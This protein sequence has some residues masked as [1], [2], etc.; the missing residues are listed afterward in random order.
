[1]RSILENRIQNA[2]EDNQTSASEYAGDQLQYGIEDISTEAGHIVVDASQSTMRKIRK[3]LRSRQVKKHT[4]RQPSFKPPT[5]KQPAVRQVVWTV[6]TPERTIKGTQK[7]IKTTAQTS[8]VTIKTAQLTA[9]TAQQTAQAAAKARQAALATAKAVTTA[10][11]VTAKAVATA[12]K[13]IIAAAKELVAAIAAG[14][15]VSVVIIIALMLVALIVGSCFGIFFS[16][17]DTGSST[18]M[19]SVVN[20]INSDYYARLETIRE[21]NTHDKLEMSEARAVWPEVLAIYAVKVNYDL[22]SPQEVAS[23]DSSKQRQLQEIFWAMNQIRYHLETAEETVIT[24]EA[25][26]DGNIVTT[27]SIQTVTTLYIHVTHKTAAAMAQEHDFSDEQQQMLNE[28]LKDENASLWSAVLYGIHVTNEQIVTVARSQLGNIGGESYWRWYGFHSHVEWCAC[29]VSWCANECGY[30]DLGIIPKF[31]SC[32][33]GVQWFKERGQWL[34]RTAIPT[35]GMIIFFDWDNEDGT[36]GMQDGRPDHV[37]IVSKVENGFVY[38]I[39]G[40]SDNSCATQQYPVGYF[41]IYGYGV[42]VY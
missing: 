42:P 31:A 17:E 11:K 36:S 13:A 12:V 26:E 18:S 10:A 35:P 14:G 23:M 7:T 4:M 15:W 9:K 8:R 33:V 28:L 19:Q 39:E 21:E 16:N 29:F 3:R 1:M 25:D 41:E 34:D 27:E 22:D 24:E 6:K 5:R 40:N 38:T 32:S 20:G 30:I 37:G 2:T